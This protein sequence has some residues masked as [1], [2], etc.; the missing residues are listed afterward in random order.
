M[1][2][3]FIV[4]SL[5]F[6]FSVSLAQNSQ[7]HDQNNNLKIKIPTEWIEKIRY[8]NTKQNKEALLTDF[9]RFIK[10]LTL[11]KT[12]YKPIVGQELINPLFANLDSEPGDELIC[13]LGWDFENPSVAVFKKIGENWFLLYMQHYRMKYQMPDI[14]VADNG[15]KNKIFYFRVT[16]ISGSP[17]NCDAYC[18][19]KLINNKV[20]PCLEL[21]HGVDGY[22]GH[23]FVNRKMEMEFSFD[24]KTDKII[25]NY[26]YSFY[27][28]SEDYNDLGI[29]CNNITLAE[30]SEEILYVWDSKRFTYKPVYHKGPYHLNDKKIACFPLFGDSRCFVNAYHD[31]IIRLLKT[32][33]GNEK[34]C[35]QKF[36]ALVKQKR[37]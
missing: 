1:C 22:F 26:S 16:L 17:T 31:E 23:I 5:L 27:S 19:Y 14:A 18:F 28:P 8:Y 24:N 35:L 10:P 33:T 34:K 25:A 21:V 3:I 9:E 20:H 12:E 2:R 30:R 36:L 15:S 4:V 29:L 37:I 32:G 7:C 13:L 11:Y 6:S